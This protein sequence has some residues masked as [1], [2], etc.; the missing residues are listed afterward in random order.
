MYLEW[1]F[2]PLNKSWMALEGVRKYKNW[3]NK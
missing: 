2:T 1:E 3:E